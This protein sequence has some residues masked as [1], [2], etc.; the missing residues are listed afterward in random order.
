L[1]GVTSK[2]IDVTSRTIAALAEFREV[3][4]AVGAVRLL[5]LKR[6]P[7]LDRPQTPVTAT[8]GIKE[9]RPVYTE[10]D[11]AIQNGN[12]GSNHKF[13]LVA[14]SIRRPALEGARQFGRSSLGDSVDIY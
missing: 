7:Q 9:R 3:V 8:R 13:Y 5:K 14:G 6:E 12:P 4:G 2:A 10:H 11:L 1:Q